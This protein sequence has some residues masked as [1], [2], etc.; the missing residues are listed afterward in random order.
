MLLKRDGWTAATRRMRL[1]PRRPLRRRLESAYPTRRRR[2]K[3]QGAT[4]LPRGA[5]RP[6]RKEGRANQVRAPSPF[7]VTGK[8]RRNDELQSDCKKGS[9]RGVASDSNSNSEKRNHENELLRVACGCVT[10]TD[11]VF[12]G[13]R[14]SCN[15]RRRSST[16]GSGPME[17]RQLTQTEGQSAAELGAV[18]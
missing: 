10:L 11:T 15:T 2:Q 8:K 3:Q 7:L 18:G 4:H 17:W 12:A 1:G 13:T 14:T 9:P 16:R 6:A 5:T